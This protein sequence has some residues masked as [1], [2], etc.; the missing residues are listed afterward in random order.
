MTSSPTPADS[1][2]LIG[3]V[4]STN[5]LLNSGGGSGGAALPERTQEAASTVVVQSGP[6][7]PSGKGSGKGGTGV[8]F[9]INHITQCCNLQTEDWLKIF[10]T[11]ALVIAAGL[12]AFFAC[13]SVGLFHFEKFIGPIGASVSLGATGALVVLSGI[14]LC[15]SF[16][17]FGPP[18]GIV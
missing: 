1:N 13:Y 16:K 4:G 18:T 9:V 3:S 5:P 15:L 12:V 14:L 8:P 7:V 10:A 11:I 6:P 17:K 2:P